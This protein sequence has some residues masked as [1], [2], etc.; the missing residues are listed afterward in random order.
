MVSVLQTRRR[1]GVQ[2]ASKFYIPKDKFILKIK[3]Y[4]QKRWSSIE[5]V[6]SGVQRQCSGF[7]G[8]SAFQYNIKVM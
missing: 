8:G 6:M 7:L 5:Q 3:D 4:Q 1:C 2:T